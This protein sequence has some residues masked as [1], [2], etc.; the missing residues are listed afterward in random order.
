M[1]TQIASGLK[2]LADLGFVHRD[3]A[4]RNCL[5]GEK[6]AIKIGDF[7]MANPLYCRDYYQNEKLG[8]YPLPIRWMAWESIL[9]VSIVED[10]L[11]S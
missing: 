11:V 8:P 3:L 7:G 5:I 2:Y 6:F 10:S 9:T 4:T 1:A